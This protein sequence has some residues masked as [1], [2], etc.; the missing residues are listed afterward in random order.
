MIVETNKVVS[1]D[2]TLKDADG[3]VL[4]SSESNGPLTYLHGA[5]NIIPGLEAA[6]NAKS[7]GDTLTAVIEPE[8]AYGVREDS[9]VAKVPRQNLQGIEDLSVGVQLRAQTP[10]G[11]L[12]VRVVDMDDETVTLDAN[13][14]LAGVALHFDVTVV[15]VRDATPEELAH[16]H[17]HGAGGQHH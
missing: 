11:P 6:L 17:V 13:H 15:E 5:S 10:S 8:D 2:Y 1:I 16:G 9:R 4:D 12:V 14:P 7:V 3:Q